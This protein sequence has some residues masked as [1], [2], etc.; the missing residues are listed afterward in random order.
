MSRTIALCGFTDNILSQFI[1]NVL[2]VPACIWH[3]FKLYPEVNYCRVIQWVLH[4]GVVLLQGIHQL[5]KVRLLSRIFS[6]LRKTDFIELK[7]SKRNKTEILAVFGK[8]PHHYIIMVI[9][10]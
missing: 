8:G 2:T 9:T 5:M 3:L 10:V 1:F 4:V 6:Y 7:L